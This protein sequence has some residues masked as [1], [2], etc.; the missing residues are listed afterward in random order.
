MFFLRRYMLLTW[1]HKTVLDNELPLLG[2]WP[3]SCDCSSTFQNL[4]RQGIE[5]KEEDSERDVGVQELVHH[6]ELNLI[7]K[8]AVNS[9][10][11]YLSDLGLKVEIVHKGDGN[12]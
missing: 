11:P 9:G 10:D 7:Q 1:N 5:A 4:Q 2:P 12:G 6:M 8:S 3:L